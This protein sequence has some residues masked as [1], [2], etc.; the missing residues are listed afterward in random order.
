[1]A[2]LNLTFKLG[3]A[4]GVGIAYGFLDIAGFDASAASQTAHDAWIIKIA[5]CGISAVLLIPAIPILW[6]FPITKE[7]QRQ[8]RRQIEGNAK[9][10]NLENDRSK[11]TNLQQ[12]ARLP[13]QTSAYLLP[14]K[15]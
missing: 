6:K 4:L 13:T 9:N 11:L 12:S 14:D 10:N 3:L 5:F 7:V 2:A 8:L 15:S 1:M